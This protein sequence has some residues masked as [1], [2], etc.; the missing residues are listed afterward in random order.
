MIFIYTSDYSKC[1]MTLKVK[2]KKWKIRI[3]CGED[4]K[5]YMEESA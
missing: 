3:S 5:K 1:F 4:Q 2:V